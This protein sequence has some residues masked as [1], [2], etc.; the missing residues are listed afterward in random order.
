MNLDP[1]L[2]VALDEKCLASILRYLQDPLLRRT[3]I[4]EF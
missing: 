1:D 2:R 3:L 4:L